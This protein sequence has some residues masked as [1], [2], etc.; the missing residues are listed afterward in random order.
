MRYLLLA[1]AIT[2]TGCSTVVPVARKFPEAPA[3]LRTACPDLRQTETTTQLSKVIETVVENYGSYHEC[4]IR[5]ES[6]NEWYDTQKKIFD[7]LK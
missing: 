3:E 7:E 6:W 1:L 2:I 4:K 5:V